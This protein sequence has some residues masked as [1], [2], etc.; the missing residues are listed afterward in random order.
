LPA[1]HPS[2]SLFDTEHLQKNLSERTIRSGAITLTSQ[3]AKLVLQITSTAVLARLL[4][5]TDFGLVA[6]IM[7]VIALVALL[8]DAG[9]S[10]ATIQRAK[11]THEQVS[12]LFWANCLMGAVL[13]LLTCILAPAM[14]WFYKEPQLTN[15]TLVYAITF[16]LVS[17]GIQHR[18][19]L[20]RQMRFAVLAVI[21]IAAI[22]VG[23]TTAILFALNGAEYWALIAM[24]LSSAAVGTVLSWILCPWRPG[25]PNRGSGVRPM[26]AFGIN[27]TAFNIINRISRVVDNILI[28]RLYGAGVLGMY[29]KAYRLLLFPLQQIN[30]P[31]GTVALPTLSILQNQHQRYRD[32]YSKGIEMISFMGKP[33][34]VFLFVAADEVIL[35]FLGQQWVEA[36][37]IFRALGPAAL[38]ATT[39]VASGWIYLSSGQTKRQLKW[40]TFASLIFTASIVAGLPWGAMGV[41][42]AVSASRLTLKV[43]GLMYCYAKTPVKLSDFGLAIWRPA[44]ASL[45]AGACLFGIEMTLLTDV[46]P[47]FT[48]VVILLTVYAMLYLFFYIALPGGRQ[49]LNFIFETVRKIRPEKKKD[50]ADK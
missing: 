3:A 31:L 15:I 20:K 38:M 32:Y 21:E 22:V 9:L 29:S 6:M 39:N 8:E 25:L 48:R 13:L 40:G 43:P 4:K 28:G 49:S 19:L 12:N 10:K 11:L 50:I 41:A 35:F 7:A 5:P 18:A 47:V 34:A 45:T 1:N 33:I 27:L 2:S 37:P 16:P 23:I 26:L 36:I 24:P 46:A 14:A 42:Y 30:R 17:I 44:T